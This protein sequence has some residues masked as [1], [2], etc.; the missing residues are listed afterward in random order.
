VFERSLNSRL[1]SIPQSGE[2]PHR[3][4]LCRRD[5]VA[6]TPVV[7]PIGSVEVFLDELLPPRFRCQLTISSG[8]S[9]LK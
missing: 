3:N 4:R 1:A 8:V 9:S 7:L 2:T 5:V 6:R